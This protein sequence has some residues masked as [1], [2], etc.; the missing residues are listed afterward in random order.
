M[1]SAHD[2]WKKV[3]SFGH[4]PD[5]CK[6]SMKISKDF[7]IIHKLMISSI[8]GIKVNCNQM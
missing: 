6:I 3:P 4:V 5:T 2:T 7:E 8:T 1:S